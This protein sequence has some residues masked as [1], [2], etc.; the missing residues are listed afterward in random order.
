MLGFLDSTS[1]IRFLI[2][3]TLGMVSMLVI[4]ALGKWRR[5]DQKFKVILRYSMFKASL[6]WATRNPVSKANRQCMVPNSF[7]PRIW[8]QRKKNL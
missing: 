7:N 2:L 5:E 1:W 6:A 3:H 8:E 4:S